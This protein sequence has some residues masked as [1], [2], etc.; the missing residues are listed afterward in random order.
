MKVRRSMTIVP[1]SVP[2]FVEKSVRLEADVV[3][4]DLQDAVVKVD[5]AKRQAREVAVAAIRR[6]G[7]RC[8]ELCVRV[9]SPGSPWFIDDLKAV[10]EAG[11]DGI[12]LTHAYGLA[13]VLFAERCIMAFANGRPV[14]IHLSLDM[15]SCLFELDEIA[16][17]STLITSVWLSSG[18][19][20]LE[21][22][23]ASHGPFATQSD[24]W[25][26][27]ARSKIVTIARAKGWNAG[28]IMRP[29][30]TEPDAL[31]AALRRSR[32]FG[33]DGCAIVVPRLIPI[34]NEVFG[35]TA[36]ELAWAKDL[37]EKW[38]ALAAG[39]EENRD[40]HTIDGRTIMRPGYEYA[41]RV[42]H[43]DAVLRGDPEAVESYRKYGLAS[44]DYL[45]ERRAA[46]IVAAA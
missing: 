7:Y 43:Y 25:L 45:T 12:R 29:L 22:G 40:F 2:T 19:F 13:D 3:V 31:R 18:D 34:V 44:G 38:E 27:Y 35:V 32:M 24:E 5:S 28:D 26:T 41:L 4:L 37:A 46:P 33:F 9:N 6:G 11:V 30:P 8:R 23:S 20:G 42:I 17:Q 10:I 21:M 1:A 16:K 15:P 14:D 36:E 39:P